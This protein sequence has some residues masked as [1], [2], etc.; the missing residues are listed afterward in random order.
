MS[1]Y[2]TIAGLCKVP[3]TP[4]EYR[5]TAIGGACIYAEGV[6]CVKSFSCT[7]IVLGLKR[8]CLKFTGEGLRIEQF[9]GGDAVIKG[10]VRTVEKI[11]Y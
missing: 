2:E 9:C 5:I 4:E 3:L 11:S 7:E 6:V 1:F 8:A 10:S